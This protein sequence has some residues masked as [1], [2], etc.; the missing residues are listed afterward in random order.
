MKKSMVRRLCIGVVLA[1]LGLSAWHFLLVPI[2]DTTADSGSFRE[3]KAHHWPHGWAG[4]LEVDRQNHLP[5]GTT[6]RSRKKHRMAQE[7]LWAKQRLVK[8]AAARHLVNSG[9]TERK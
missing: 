8:Q 4:G 2:G 6:Y 5:D 9:T 7:A 1:L 3:D